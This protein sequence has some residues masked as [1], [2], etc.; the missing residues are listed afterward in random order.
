M[1]GSGAY[2]LA[3]GEIIKLK[4]FYFLKVDGIRTTLLVADYR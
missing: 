1:I 4:T 2:L 3:A